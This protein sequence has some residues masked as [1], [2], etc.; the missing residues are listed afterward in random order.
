[1][2]QAE[3]ANFVI[4]RRLIDGAITSYEPNTPEFTY[5]VSA[6]NLALDLMSTNQVRGTIARLAIDV[7]NQ[8]TGNWPQWYQA[9]NN[10][11][12]AAERFVDTFLQIVRGLFPMVVVDERINN[13][14]LFGYHPRGAW[15]NQFVARN[16]SIH[17]NARVRS[18]DSQH[19][20]R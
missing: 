1:M 14:N 18:H 19:P 20:L 4:L 5:T 15:D 8:R 10:N 6:I 12:I 7:E 9:F 16:Q 2:A 13:P 3:V 11:V 17:I